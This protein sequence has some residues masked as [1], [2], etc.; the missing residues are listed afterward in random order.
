MN[1]ENL[2]IQSFKA[3]TIESG[4]MYGQF[5]IDSLKPGQ[6]LTFGNILRR[7]LLN[8]IGGI[9]ITAVRMAGVDD[10]FSIIPGVREDVLE[11][12]LNLKGIVLKNVTDDFSCGRLKIKGPAVVTANSI[13]LPENLQIV[14]SNQY[15]GTISDSNILE[16]EFQFEYGT[17]YRLA[18]KTFDNKYDDYLELDAI[19]QPIQKVNFRVEEEYN[20]K[21]TNINPNDRIERLFIDIWTNGSISPEKAIIS[22]SDFII[23]TFNSL[24]KNE[25]I[26]KSEITPKTKKKTPKIN[27]Y[28]DIAIEELEFSVRVYNCLKRAK[29]YTVGELLTYSPEK[30]KQLRNFGQKSAD[31][32]CTILKNKFGIVYS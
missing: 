20:E 12:L 23:K 30:L 22:A 32:V 7:V 3:K 17:G 6:G 24:V 31:E 27:P 1:I 14:N 16:I 21:Y 28:I 18:G 10:E 2:Y 13:Q 11:I 29:I 8:D 9:A 26:V 5:L 25:I 15:I 4:A 19:F